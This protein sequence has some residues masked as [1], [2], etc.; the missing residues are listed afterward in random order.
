LINP[1]TGRPLQGGADP[2]NGWDGDSWKT[3]ASLAQE[4]QRNPQ[5]S[6]NELPSTPAAEVDP[7]PSRPRNADDPKT[8]EDAVPDW[9]IEKLYA[10]EPWHNVNTPTAVTE[11]W[12]RLEAAAERIESYADQW[13]HLDAAERRA[14]PTANATAYE[15]MK[16]GKTPPTTVTIVD[17]SAAKRAALANM[18][19]AYRLAEEARRDYDRTVRA[20][21]PAW[22]Q[23]IVDTLPPLQPAARQAFANFHREFRKWRRTLAAIHA[24]TNPLHHV[25]PPATSSH[26]ADQWKAARDGIA[27]IE[28]ILGSNN[29]VLTGEWIAEPPGIDPPLWRRQELAGDPYFHPEL[30]RIERAERDAG[31]TITNYLV[32]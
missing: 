12:N 29:P 15:A 25:D 31:K 18:A 21:L 1:K 30:R 7:A 3:P 13:H 27:A 24:M 11:A 32:P 5:R 4:V 10:H 6:G 2:T 9:W 16:A 8:P 26:H 28:G 22:R 14:T 17:N 19:A 23:K 20:E